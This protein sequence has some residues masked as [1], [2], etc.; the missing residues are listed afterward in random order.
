MPEKNPFY[1]T[2]FAGRKAARVPA[3][4]EV[5]A[6]EADNGVAENKAVARKKTASKKG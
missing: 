6:I 4:P 1:E 2:T 5:K 3:E